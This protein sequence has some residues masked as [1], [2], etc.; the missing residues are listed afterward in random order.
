MLFAMRTN[1]RT[2]GC[3]HIIRASVRANEIVYVRE[4]GCFEIDRRD[5]QVRAGFKD[6]VSKVCKSLSD[7]TRSCDDSSA[8]KK[9]K[10]HHQR[11]HH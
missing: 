7:D 5:E 2:C 6:A 9:L 1:M 8:L 10:N 3:K 11:S 4:S